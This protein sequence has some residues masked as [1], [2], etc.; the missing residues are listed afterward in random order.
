MTGRPAA[1]AAITLVQNGK[2]GILLFVPIYNQGVGKESALK[3]FSLGVFAVPDLVGVALQ[4]RDV[5]DLDY[6]LADVTEPNAPAPLTADSSATLGACAAGHAPL[7][8]AR[9]AAVS[10]AR[11]GFGGRTWTFRVAPRPAYVARHSDYADYFVLLGG[12]LFT[13]FV[14]GFVL[15]VTDRQRQL[16]AAREKALEDQKFALDQHAIVSIT[17]AQ[18]RDPLRQRPILRRS[19]ATRASD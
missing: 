4:G 11:I 13:A 15:V 6:C 12:F 1:T 7:P 2:T 3:G 19:P 5:A 18:G 16:V 14:S 10:Q 17:D 9:T 8:D